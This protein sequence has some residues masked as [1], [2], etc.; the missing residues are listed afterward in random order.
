M[1][2][3]FRCSSSPYIQLQ[4]PLLLLYNSANTSELFDFPQL[5]VVIL[6]QCL[7]TIA[8]ISAPKTHCVGSGF[9]PL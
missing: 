1:L 3:E 8:K 7:S 4:C 9:K 6:K 5:S 2:C